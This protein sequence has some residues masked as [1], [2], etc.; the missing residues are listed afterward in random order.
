MPFV[1]KLLNGFEFHIIAV[2]V[3][4]AF[5]VK[6]KEFPHVVNSAV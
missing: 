5:A 1:A 2:I 4:L 6:H 3:Y